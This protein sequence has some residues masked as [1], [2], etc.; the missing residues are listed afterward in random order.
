MGE[1]A[2]IITQI[3]DIKYVIFCSLSHSL[4]NLLKYSKPFFHRSLCQNIQSEW[5]YPTTE[6]W[7]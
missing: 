4:Y 6:T 2:E 3:T 7:K 1:G 5:T